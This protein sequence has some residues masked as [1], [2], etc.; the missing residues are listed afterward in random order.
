MGVVRESRQPGGEGGRHEYPAKRSGL[1]SSRRKERCIPG[2]GF[3]LQHAPTQNRGISQKLKFLTVTDRMQPH[4]LRYDRPHLKPGIRLSRGHSPRPARPRDS[5]EA[6]IIARDPKIEVRFRNINLPCEHSLTG[7]ALN[8]FLP[9]YLIGHATDVAGPNE[10]GP[11]PGGS[12]RYHRHRSLQPFMQ[13][14]SEQNQRSRPFGPCEC[15]LG[16]IKFCCRDLRFLFW[17]QRASEN[18]R[19]SELLSRALR[20][21]HGA[22]SDRLLLETRW[23]TAEV[24]S[25]RKQGWPS[26]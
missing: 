23:S 16:Q 12:P 11:Y 3:A 15:R 8:L 24:S 5:L 13:G 1:K 19:R 14:H 17:R 22:K 18:P 6:R 25:H 20:R 7:K 10:T 4:S 2:D 9:H 21:S 26:G